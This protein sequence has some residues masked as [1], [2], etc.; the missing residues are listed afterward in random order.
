MKKLLFII[1]IFF[2]FSC[3][4]TPPSPVNQESSAIAIHAGATF[5]S[6]LTTIDCFRPEKVYFI[7]LNDDNSLMSN[8]L[9]ESTLNVEAWWGDNLI[10]RNT[11]YAFNL[12]PGRYA[13]VAA[14]GTGYIYFLRI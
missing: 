1:A 3:A 13:A 8:N 5:H 12:P 14:Y 4:T 6:G 7:K 2:C 9:I 11:T 10:G